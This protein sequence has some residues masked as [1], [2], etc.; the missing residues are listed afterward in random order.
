M[1]QIDI[2]VYC[3]ASRRWSLS[4]RHGRAGAHTFVFGVLARILLHIFVNHHNAMSLN[5]DDVAVWAGRAGRGRTEC[6]HW[7]SE[8]RGFGAR[9]L[10]PC[11]NA[12]ACENVL[13][14][15][16]Q[17]CMPS[18]LPLFLLFARWRGP[19]QTLQSRSRGR[20]LRRAVL[21]QPEYGRDDLGKARLMAPACVAHTTL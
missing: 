7:S 17:K 1:P 19:R 13:R 9:S 14:S 11:K 8:D 21:A 6:R 5:C 10:A 2:V 16:M 15:C 18:L 20:R 3:V 12:G 4:P